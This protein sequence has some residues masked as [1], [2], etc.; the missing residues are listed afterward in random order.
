MNITDSGQDLPR[1]ATPP[2]EEELAADC[3]TLRALV[4][5]AGLLGLAEVE[6]VS[7]SI[8]EREYRVR[9]LPLLDQAVRLNMQATVSLRS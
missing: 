9:K 4:R 1:G 6:P 5:F 8:F 3:Y 2:T 7:D